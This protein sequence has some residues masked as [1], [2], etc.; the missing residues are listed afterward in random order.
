MFYKIASYEWNQIALVPFKRYVHL[1]CNEFA[2]S[3]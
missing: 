2:L 3:M 1:K